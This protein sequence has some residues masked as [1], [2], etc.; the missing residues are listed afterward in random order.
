MELGVLLYILVVFG[1]GGTLLLGS[2]AYLAWEFICRLHRP[3]WS[4]RTLLAKAAIVLSVSVFTCLLSI[5]LRMIWVTRV[6]A[7]PGSYKAVGVWGSA[8][9]TMRPDRS[10]VEAWNFKNAYNGKP[11][12]EGM[13]QGTWR[14][15]E[16]DWLTR[17]IYLGPFK[18]LAEYDRNHV[19]ATHSAN[20][21][22]YSG[23]TLI[24]LDAG[25]DIV[26]SK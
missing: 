7:I 24:E 16:R 23:F 17:D 26:F 12:G 21:M 14:T 18:G 19:P 15:A 5:P 2:M 13:I 3:A 20:V 9:L 10:F 11:E 4:K 25:S 8:T 22:G 1:F 6:G